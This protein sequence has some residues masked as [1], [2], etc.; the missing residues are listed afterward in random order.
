MTDASWAMERP[1]RC[2]S[3]SNSNNGS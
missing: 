3:T 2:D 1:S